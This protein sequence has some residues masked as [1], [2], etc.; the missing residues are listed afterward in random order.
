MHEMMVAQSLLATISKE[1]VKH[2]AKPLSAK[3]SCGMLNPVNDEVLHFA[4]EAI[5]KDTPCEG[6]SIQVE[7]KPLRAQCKDCSRDFNVEFSQPRCPECGGEDFELLPD[8][9]LVLEEIEF[10]TE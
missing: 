10:Q 7:H 4:F 2:N 1:A 6:V 5:A 3:I 9:P 8:A